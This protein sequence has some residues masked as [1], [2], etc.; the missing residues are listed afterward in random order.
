MVKEG[1][2]IDFMGFVI[3][4]SLYCNQAYLGQPRAH[5]IRVRQCQIYEELAKREDSAPIFQ[6]QWPVVSEEYFEYAD[7]LDAV[8]DYAQ[9]K[10]ERKRERPFVF[11]EIG[12]G[13]GHWTFTAHRALMQKMP[14]ASFKYLMVDVVDELLPV[15]QRLAILNG[16]NMTG[17]HDPPLQFH[18]GFIGASMNKREYKSNEKASH[19][20]YAEMWGIN[21][22]GGGKSNGRSGAISFATLLDTY[23]MPCEL[24]MVDV[25]IQGAE[26]NLFASNDTIDLLTARAR[27]LHI[28]LHRAPHYSQLHLAIENRFRARGWATKWYFGTITG[29]RRSVLTSLGPIA[30]GD[31]V[32]S[33]VNPRT[34][35]QDL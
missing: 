31:G 26:Y 3:M 19:Q 6:T 13:Y 7:V 8:S 18:A 30:F 1:L 32:L 25:D 15:V 28:G 11:V 9:V 35:C 23:R 2:L 21:Q 16:V 29:D 34:S 12:A 20:G 17:S 14:Q 4:K 27:R 33:L 24:D 22:N 5:A 10:R